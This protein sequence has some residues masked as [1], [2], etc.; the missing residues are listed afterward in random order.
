VAALFRRIDALRRPGDAAEIVPPR[1]ALDRR[2]EDAD[3]LE[4]QR[5]DALLDRVLDRACARQESG[6][7]EERQQLMDAASVVLDDNTITSHVKRIRRKFQ[8]IDPPSMRFKRSTGWAIAG[9]SEHPAATARDRADHSESCRWAGCQYARELESALRISQENSLHAAA[10]TI[11]N[12]L[13]AEASRVFTDVETGEP[14][15]ASQ[16]IFTS[17]PARR[18]LARRLS[19]GLGSRRRGPDP[20]DRTGLAARLLAG[21]T[22]RYVFL[23]LEVDDPRFDPEPADGLPDQGGFDRVDLK[24]LRPD[25][26]EE[27]Y[28]FATGAP[29]PTFAQSIVRGD[30]GVGHVTLAP[31]IQA[32]WLQTSGGYHLEARIPRT[33]V[34]S[35][36]WIEAVRPAGARAGFMGPDTSQGGRVSCNPGP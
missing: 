34:G 12:A 28:F 36:L 18:A 15:D 9:S 4:R 11:A 8:Q 6:P 7:R 17:S 32:F 30:D 23:Y 33:L 31:R 5:R 29:G 26:A 27:S 22:D 13:S 25:G 14:F 2:R 3:G 1:P 16:A 35:R 24:L 20:A 10:G 21:H 19:G